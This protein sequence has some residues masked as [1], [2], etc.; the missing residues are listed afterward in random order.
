VEMKKYSQEEALKEIFEENKK[1]LSGILLVYKHRYKHNKL[2]QKSIDKILKDHKF[3]VFQPVVYIKEKPKK[4]KKVFYVE[5]V[6]YLTVFI[7]VKTY[8]R[9]VRVVTVNDGG[10]S[11]IEVS[12]WFLKRLEQENDFARLKCDKYYIDIHIKSFKLK[13]TG[14]INICFGSVIDSNNL[15]RIIVKQVKQIEP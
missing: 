7:D 2:A 4:K 12:K 3:C 6:K 1:P 10:T 13:D 9:I 14:A 5:K 8:N 15:S 11:D